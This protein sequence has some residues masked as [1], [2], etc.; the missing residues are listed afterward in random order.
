[1][2]APKITEFFKSQKNIDTSVKINTV[3]NEFYDSSLQEKIDECTLVNC[4]TEKLQLLSTLDKSKQKLEQIRQSLDVCARIRLKKEAAI[5]KLKAGIPDSSTESG[6]A[7]PAID[8]KTIFLKYS[9]IFD[10]KDLAEIRSIIDSK[11]NDSTFVLKIIRCLYKD[12]IEKVGLITVSGRS[13]SDQAKQQMTPEK[14]SITKGMFDE[15]LDILQLKLCD[16]ARRKKELSTHI[17]NA[18]KNITNAK[19][20][21][22][23]DEKVMQEINQKFNSNE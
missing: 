21:K 13:R 11:P 8:K 5:L 15:R 9:S 17:R 12:N 10:A 2:A 14:H 6:A 18:F 23:V 20:G 7:T 19:T 16:H 22:N 3:S 4:A 1:M